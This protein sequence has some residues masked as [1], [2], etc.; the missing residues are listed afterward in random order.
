MKK[1][2]PKYYLDI[3]N[4]ITNI[5]VYL[6]DKRDFSVFS[7][8]KLIQDGVERNLITIGEV[9]NILLKDN[10]NIPITHARKIVDAR[11]RIIHTYDEID[12][13]QIWS[14]VVYHIPLLKEETTNLLNFDQ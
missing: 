7:S 3:L 4:C 1:S 6:G 5:E 8:S 12:M 11:N 9:V 13:Y 10:P 14:I 2:L